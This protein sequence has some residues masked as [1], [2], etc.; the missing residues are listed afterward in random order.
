MRR[1]SARRGRIAGFYVAA[2]AR[3]SRPAPRC[4]SYRTP[5]P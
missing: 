1:A 5:A 3:T 2:A 4:T